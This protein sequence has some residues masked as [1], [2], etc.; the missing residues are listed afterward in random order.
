MGFMLLPQRAFLTVAIL[1]TAA[2]L[3]WANEPIDT[4]LKPDLIP[5]LAMSQQ[6]MMLPGDVDRPAKLE[7]TLLTPSGTGPF[8]LAVL[9]H[10]E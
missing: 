10:G 3:A 9:N 1:L 5:S 8:P 6:V 4:T 2:G 7:V